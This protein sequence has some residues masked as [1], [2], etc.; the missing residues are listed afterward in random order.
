[1]GMKGLM[2][3]FSEAFDGVSGGL[4]TLPYAV[5]ACLL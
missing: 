3:S 2:M 4:T 1:M 5:I